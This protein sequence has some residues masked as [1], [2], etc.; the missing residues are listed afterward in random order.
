MICFG[1]FLN[2]QAGSGS[3]PGEDDENITFRAPYYEGVV[4]CELLL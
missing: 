2:G 4:S 3:V 1:W